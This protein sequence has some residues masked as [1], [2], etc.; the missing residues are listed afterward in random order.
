MVI[1]QDRMLIP[2]L[3]KWRYLVSHG[4]PHL[5][6][7]PWADLQ[8]TWMCLSSSSSISKS[9][10]VLLGCHS[11]CW[12][13]KCHCHAVRPVKECHH[14][15]LSLSIPPAVWIWIGKWGQM[16]AREDPIFHAHFQ[17]PREEWLK[18]RGPCSNVRGWL[19]KALLENICQHRP[20]HVKAW[21]EGALHCLHALH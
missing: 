5:R 12:Y 4:E 11:A 14:W 6:L 2:S 17:L 13:G 3:L 1:T 20:G 16:T 19:W 18:Y 8:Q 10:K 9:P 15:A 21:R 7:L